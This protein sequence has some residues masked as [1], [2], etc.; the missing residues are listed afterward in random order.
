MKVHIDGKPLFNQKTGIGY[1]CYNLIEALNSLDSQSKYI[2]TYNTSRIRKNK[3]VSGPEKYVWYPYTK[4]RRHVGTTFPYN[5]ALENFLGDFDI[6][7]GTAFSVLPTRK[8]KKVLTV[9]DAAYKRFPE[10]IE[11]NN[12]A[13]LTEWLP[14]F[15][16]KSDHILAI[17]ESGKEE[18]IHYFNVKPEKISVTYLAADQAYHPIPLEDSYRNVV[19]EKYNLPSQFILYT[20]TIEPR[21][22]LINLITAYQKVLQRTQCDH[23]LVLAGGKG[24]LYDEVFAAVNKLNLQDKVRFLGYVDFHDLPYLYNLAEVFAYV[25]KYEGFGLPPLEAMQCGTPVLTS[26]TSSLP[27]VVGDAAIMVE[28]ANVDEIAEHLEALISNQALR[29]EY[30]KKGLQRAAQFSWEKTAASTIEAYKKLL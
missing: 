22:N 17:S 2:A 24:W 27:E 20:G 16:E 4:L 1:Y 18:L 26:N 29:E 21:K 14:Y 11:K 3:L 6:Y 15:I 9:Y 23:S 10:T 13:F 8:A 5:L 28:P 25:S 7:H 12:F 19:R 30:S